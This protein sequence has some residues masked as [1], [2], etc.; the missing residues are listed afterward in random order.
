MPYRGQSHRGDAAALRAVRIS[1]ELAGG[2]PGLQICGDGVGGAGEDAVVR[3]LWGR[4]QLAEGGV[5]HVE[6]GIGEAKTEE[7]FDDQGALLGGQDLRAGGSA[8]GREEA[9]PDLVD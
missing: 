7:V 3:A 1:S 5:V 4:E 2:D 9:E 8:L 6:D